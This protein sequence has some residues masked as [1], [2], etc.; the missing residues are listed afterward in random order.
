MSA[1]NRK[2]TAL[3]RA[4]AMLARRAL[5][6]AELQEG[7]ARGGFGASE[8]DAAIE[9]LAELGFLG[10]EAL[11]ERTV[12]KLRRKGLG[13]HRIEAE[14]RRRGLP[15]HL[16]E[17]EDED[18]ALDTA[19]DRQLSRFGEK[20]DPQAARR[21]AMRVARRGFDLPAVRRA[22]EARG[23]LSGLGDI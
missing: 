2:G 11:A 23:W 22:M 3:D 14:L 1:P 5:S 20:P 4:T 8:V 19:L 18:R 21:V 15:P 7:L 13:W 17:Q 12:E 9:R 16:M 6:R 10:D